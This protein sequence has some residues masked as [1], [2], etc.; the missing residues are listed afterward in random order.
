MT[1]RILVV[2]PSWVGDMVMAQALLMQLRAQSDCQIDV[3]A[4]TWTRALLERMPQVHKALDWPFDHGQLDLAARYRLGVSLRD[5]HYDQAI[6]LPNSFKSAIPLLSARIPLRTG[7]RGEARGLLLND[8]R[9]LDSTRYPQ[10]VQ[11][12]VAL[13][14]APDAPLPDPL[15]RPAL[16]TD[17]NSVDTA[18]HSMDMRKIA[19]VLALCPG[20][21]FGDAKRW[22]SEHYAMLAASHL[23]RGWQVWIFGSTRDAVV[24]RQVEKLLPEGL[25]S[26][27]R[28]LAGQTTLSQAIDLL[29]LADA[30][31]SNDSGLMHVA[32]ALNRPLVALYGPT[33]T[34]FTP[35]MADAVRLLATDIDCRPCFQRQCPLGHKRCLTEL[36]PALVEESLQQLG[37]DALK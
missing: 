14:L 13:A 26:R 30:V 6:V 16:V 11:R 37:A 31:V 25:R 32:A 22:P 5:Q 3:L 2:G 9:H 1:R 17:R 28:D 15:P 21:E 19:P 33:S 7:W 36:S 27:C 24:S 29:S 12:F 23:E 4:P 35:P 20:A 10:M 18:L 8:C 34:E